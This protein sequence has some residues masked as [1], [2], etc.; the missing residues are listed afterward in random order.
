MNLRELLGYERILIQCHNNPDP[1]ALA[2]GYGLYEY[3]KSHGKDVHLV[4]GG[5]DR[6]QKSNIKLMISAL[7]IPVEFYLDYEKENAPLG[8][9]DL[10]ITV[11]C[12][13]GESNVFRIEAEN[14]VIIDHH[15][16][17]PILVYNADTMD[18]RSELGSCATLVWS[19]LKEEGFPVA[20]YANLSTALYYGLF[21]D[22]GDFSE[23]SYPLD[24]DMRDEL[25]FDKMLV[26]QLNNSKIS[27]EELEIA[28][29]ALIKYVYNT[30]HRYALIHA[31]PCDPN[32]LGY[33]IDLVLQVDVID[34]CVVYNNQANGFKFS[35]RSCIKEVK[36]NELAAY[37]ADGIGG[38]G[39]H[40]DKAGGFISLM[41]FAESQN[42][43]DIDTYM[44][45]RMNSYF[46]TCEII[47][48]GDYELDTTG[49]KLCR[50]KDLVVGY[51]DPA[52]VVPIGSVIQVRTLE[53]DVDIK[54]E[55]KEYIMIGI[56]GEVYPIAKKR[57]ESDYEKVSDSYSLVTEY[58][59]SLRCNTTGTVIS[60]LTKYAKSCR[61]C[62]RSQIYA[63]PID[64]IHK[65]YTVWDPQN[66]YVGN[67]GDYIACKY[68]DKK[69]IYIIRKDVFELSYEEIEEA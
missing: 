7:E 14:I 8:K 47:H 19:M 9:D 28:G 15:Q 41:K 27:L 30:E 36:A 57:F 31:K 37:I 39:G 66:Y 29:V 48:C 64:H 6:V 20:D 61:A 52:D 55:G 63:K 67:P 65:I 45:V 5:M 54:V 68:N 49:M 58:L 26:M 12:Q 13:Y 53:G 32:V 51:V 25:L 2:S 18:I 42:E 34:T 38:G 1:D 24:K 17:S 23:L 11:D 21:T 10:L 16:V 43:M 46:T 56:L 69:D 44:A 50:K 62:S 33:I 22:T 40:M 60:D 3:F 35:V 4:Y 59:P